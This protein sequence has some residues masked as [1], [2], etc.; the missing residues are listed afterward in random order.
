MGTSDSVGFV[1]AFAAVQRVRDAC[2]SHLGVESVGIT[3][4][5]GDLCVRVNLRRGAIPPDVSDPDVRIV[6]HELLD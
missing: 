6:F 2:S 5:R 4:E 3:R 1:E